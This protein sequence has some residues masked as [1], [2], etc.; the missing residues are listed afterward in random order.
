MLCLKRSRL[1]LPEGSGPGCPLPLAG[2]GPSWP[3]FFFLFLRFFFAR[4]PMSLF[5]TSI[6]EVSSLPL[7]RYSSRSNSGSLPSWIPWRRYCS[8]SSRVVIWAGPTGV[9]TLLVSN[10]GIFSLFAINT[11]ELNIRWQCYGLNQDK[12]QQNSQGS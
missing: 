12:S 10:T 9:L 3:P 11:L 7:L 4:S 6:L 1:V 8:Y 2:G 5:E